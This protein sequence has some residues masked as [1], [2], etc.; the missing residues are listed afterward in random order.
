MSMQPQ[1]NV[2][3][4]RTWYAEIKYSNSVSLT[5]QGLEFKKT[6]NL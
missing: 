5:G 4:F 2:W 1:K 6:V 3:L